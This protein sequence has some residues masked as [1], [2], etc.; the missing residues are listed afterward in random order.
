MPTSSYV[1]AGANLLAAAMRDPAPIINLATFWQFMQVVESFALQFS[2]QEKTIPSY[3]DHIAC[4]EQIV[5]WQ[6]DMTPVGGDLLRMGDQL[7]E[8]LAAYAEQAAFILTDL[9]ER[10]PHT[11]IRPLLEQFQG[12]M[13]N[14]VREVKEVSPLIESTRNALATFEQRSIS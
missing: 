14:V 1:Q 8:A 6:N 2:D 11:Q 9:L 4:Y 5:Q 7:I 3:Q 12:A 10:R 13:D